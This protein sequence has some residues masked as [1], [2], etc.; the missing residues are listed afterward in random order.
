MP[1]ADRRTNCCATTIYP[2][3]PASSSGTAFP[4]GNEGVF[5]I[6]NN[7]RTKNKGERVTVAPSLAPSNFLQAVQHSRRAVMNRRFSSGVL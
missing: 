7:G 4:I 5:R 6:G 2:Y 1:F 3:F